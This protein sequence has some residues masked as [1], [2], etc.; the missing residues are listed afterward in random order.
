MTLIGHARVSAEDLT[1]L[2]QDQA[3]HSS[4]RGSTDAGCLADRRR[5][6]LKGATPWGDRVEMRGLCGLIAVSGLPA[7]DEVSYWRPGP[8]AQAVIDRLYAAA[9]PL[10]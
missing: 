8:E 5:F 2:L 1:L 7:D 10:R 3:R 6:A 9:E 4:G